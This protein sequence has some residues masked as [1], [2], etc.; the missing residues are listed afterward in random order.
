MKKADDF[1]LNDLRRDRVR[2]EAHRLL[3]KAD[4]FGRFPTPVQDV[5]AVARLEV[6]DLRDNSFL[7]KLREAVP[8]GFLKRALSK[9]LGVLDV[10]ASLI[11][12]DRT[13]KLVK[14]TF[15]VFHEAG[16]FFL[17]W[18]R[19]AYQVIEDCEKTL[20]PEIAEDFDREA[21]IFASEV[22]FQLDG[23]ITE[24]RDSSFG[25]RVPLD[26][27]KR[28]GASA[29]SAI[30][31]YVAK[32]HRP[33]AV[34]VLNPVEVDAQFGF[35][36]TVRRFLTSPSFPSQLGLVEWPEIMTP[37]HPLWTLIPTGN[38][39]MSSRRQI[40]LR[41]TDGARHTCLAEAFD[42]GF[43][44]FILILAEKALGTTIVI[45]ALPQK[46]SR[47]LSAR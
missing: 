18:Q 19:N 9:V 34:L 27:A 15:I 12:I 4:A 36:V 16:H 7:H 25:I 2:R 6:E 42:T 11:F 31:Q 40:A 29:Y 24:A 33:C 46:T 30:R 20:D 5:L 23:F 14:Q 44:V 3:S 39:K 32:N 37:S 22:L 26:L 10:H 41:N 17:P 8:D 43:Q 21:N 13:L 47:S 45:P 38:R 35:Q 1:N 28:Y